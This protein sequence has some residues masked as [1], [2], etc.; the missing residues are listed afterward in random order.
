MVLGAL[1]GLIPKIEGFAP[2]PSA[3][4]DSFMAMQG[5]HMALY[6]GAFYKFA[7]RLMDSQSNETFNA[8]ANDPKKLM[9]FLD[10]YSKAIT[11]QFITRLKEETDTIQRLV[12]DK[13][14]DMEILKIH[15]TV[16]LLKELP[17]AYWNAIFEVNKKI[18]EAD[19]T[20]PPPKEEPPK[21]PKKPPVVTPPKG[22][23]KKPPATKS[24]KPKLKNFS[25]NP[26]ELQKF[27]L[28]RIQEITRLDKLMIPH[29]GR[30]GAAVRGVFM[31]HIRK[32]V[33]MWKTN[34]LSSGGYTNPD[35]ENTAPWWSNDITPLLRDWWKD[36]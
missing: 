9:N 6:F 34:W 27:F 29:T 36:L 7:T 10:P 22:S 28:A 5:G 32:Q 15:Q 30:A 31:S 26:I 16:K 33:S 4:A 23:P 3:A 35:P 21:E 24:Q 25:D 12:L 8:L 18:D 2:L 1:S 19:G 14:Y 11:E 17:S 20:T 13:A